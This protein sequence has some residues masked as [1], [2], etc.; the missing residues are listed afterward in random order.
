MST[1]MM[2]LGSYQFSINTAA[3]Q[4]LQRSTDYRWAQQE[5]YGALPTLQH[6]GP[7]T[8]SI[9][10]Q[11]V[12]FG[13]FKG[14][15]GQPEALRRLAA[16]GLPQ[17]MVSGEGDVMGLWVIEKVTETQSIFAVAGL[18]RQQEFSLQLKR[19]Q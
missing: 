15:T 2:Q 3:Y 17:Q 10:L 13:E 4:S 6:T 9:T 16:Q 12:I 1:V 19:Y 8:E 14:G 11:G 18:P 5:T 7:G